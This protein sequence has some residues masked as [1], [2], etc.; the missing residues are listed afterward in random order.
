MN[1]VAENIALMKLNYVVITSVDRYDLRDGGAGH[2]VECIRH[3]RA[4]TPNT[5]IEILMP[6]FG[7]RLDRATFIQGSAP[8]CGFSKHAKPV[9]TLQGHASQYTHQ[10]WP[11]GRVGRNR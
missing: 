7:G 11:D 3:I 8:R 5:Y 10:I 6:D 4:L 9:A 2:F 1:A